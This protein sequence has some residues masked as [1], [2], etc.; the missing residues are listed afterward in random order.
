LRIKIW[1]N[2]GVVYDNQRGTP[3]DAELLVPSTLLTSGSLTIK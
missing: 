1:N 2:S 3:D